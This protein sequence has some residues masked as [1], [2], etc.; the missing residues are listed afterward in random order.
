PLAILGS[1]AAA[2]GAAA[3]LP[4][5]NPLRLAV[6]L[7][8]LFVCPGMALVRLL[9]LK[10]RVAAW[11]LAVALSLALDA[12]VAGALLYAGLWSPPAAFAILTGISV[13]GA[14]LQIASAI[15]SRRDGHPAAA[16]AAGVASGEGEPAAGV[17]PRAPGA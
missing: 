5:G 17:A 2:T 11:T 7:W 6:I 16:M 12:I 4:A 13:A 8:F 9:D 10:D 3:M 1:A 15:R 14:G